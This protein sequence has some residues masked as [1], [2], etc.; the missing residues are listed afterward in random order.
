MPDRVCSL[1]LLPLRSRF[2]SRSGRFSISGSHLAAFSIGNRSSTPRVLHKIPHRDPAF[3]V[4]PSSWLSQEAV[5]FLKLFPS[6][7][8]RGLFAHTRCVELLVSRVLYH[9]VRVLVKKILNRFL[10]LNPPRER[11]KAWGPAFFG[12]QRRVGERVP[13]CYPSAPPPNQDRHCWPQKGAARPPFSP[14]EK[15]A[16]IRYS[17]SQS[18]A[19][20]PAM[21]PRCEQS[22]TPLPKTTGCLWPSHRGRFLCQK[23]DA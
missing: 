19:A 2:Q 20:D 4:S 14:T 18:I 1:P 6:D 16:H 12:R 3:S 13:W 15:S 17:N 5:V 7:I 22:T 10:V 21:V 9:F 23:A 11:P 8:T